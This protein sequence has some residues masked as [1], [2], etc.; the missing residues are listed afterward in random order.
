MMGKTDKV[1][2]FS[3]GFTL[4]KMLIMT[5]HIKGADGHDVDPIGP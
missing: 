1:S 4:L 3:V 2:V 5:I